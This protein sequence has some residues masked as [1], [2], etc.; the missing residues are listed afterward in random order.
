MTGVDLFLSICQK[1]D[2]KIFLLGAAPGIAEETKKKLE[3][4]FPEIQISGTHAGSPHPTESAEI[5]S[6]INKSGAEILF[7]AYGAPAQE[8]W[9]YNNLKKLNTVKIA[10]GIGGAFDFIAGKKQ[11]A[12]QWMQNLG[13]EWLYRLKQEPKRIKRIINATI[14]F[15]L[16][17]FKKSKDQTP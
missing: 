10:T 1:T 4:K 5:V 2:K 14:K 15:P 6:K 13:L 16:T 17:V 9:I 8:K 7:V 3:E 12:P 11:R